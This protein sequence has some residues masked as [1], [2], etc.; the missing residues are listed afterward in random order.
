MSALA[1]YRLLIDAAMV[2]R[3]PRAVSA[4]LA[5]AGLLAPVCVLFAVVFAVMHP[6]R[7]GKVLWGSMVIPAGLLLLLWLFV[8][9]PG[10]ALMNT[11]ANAHLV[12]R[13]RRRLAELIVTVWLLVFVVTLVGLGPEGALLVTLWVIAMSMGR[14]GSPS[15]IAVGMVALCWGLVGKLVP[16]AVIEFFTTAPGYAALALLV[17]LLG[18]SALSMVLPHAGDR[19]LAQRKRQAESIGRMESADLSKPDPASNPA[20]GGYA[21]VLAR[22]C[23]VGTPRIL[24]PHAL[25]PAAHWTSMLPAYA[26]VLAVGLVF[27][28]FQP[29]GGNDGQPGSLQSSAWIFVAG[30]PLVHMAF[31]DQC[32]RRLGTAK[33]E[34]ALVRL[35]A[36][37]PASGGLNRALAIELCRNVLFSWALST[38]AAVVLALMMGV[39]ERLVLIAGALCM[40]GCAP[41]I[42]WVLD[43]YSREQPSRGRV[44][45]AVSV[46]MTATGLA[47]AFSNRIG[48]GAWLGIAVVVNAAGGW[49]AHKRWQEMVAAPIAFPAQRFD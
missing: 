7:W 42:A 18:A 45:L 1:D 33:Y 27:G 38:V 19:H 5:I 47:L 43:D 32:K 17:V 9:V 28:F 3:R 46:Q 35:A 31:I 16:G 49:L 10:A 41:S 25:G 6:H 39:G 12:P 21:R 44:I 2:Q 24:L 40:L 15:G 30:L 34:Q 13:M 22:A 48:A 26:G 4:V 29:F 37:S 11:P 8:F 20:R 36:R 23:R 14:S